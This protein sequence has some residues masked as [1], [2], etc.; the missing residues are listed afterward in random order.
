M[1]AAI[2]QLS[3]FGSIPRRRWHTQAAVTGVALKGIGSNTAR[4]R[5]RN[6]HLRGDRPPAGVPYRR[7]RCCRPAGVT[8]RSTTISFRPVANFAA[9]TAV[10]SASVPL[11]VRTTSS[12]FR[13]RSLRAFLP[14]RPVAYCVK[15]RSMRDSI[16]LIDPS[17][18]HARPHARRSPSTPPETI[19]IL[20][21]LVVPNELAFTLSD[22]DRLFV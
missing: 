14:D 11:F 15:R 13:A 10:S 2:S 22:R 4:G 1:N 7:E 20:V 12:S 9:S 8:W 18:F 16:N 3:S 17:L 21:A 6:P 19:E 5:V